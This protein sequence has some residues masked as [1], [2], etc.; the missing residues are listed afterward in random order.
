MGIKGWVWRMVALASLALMAGGPAYA[1]KAVS[2]ICVA[3]VGTGETAEAVLA[4]PGRF[5][6]DKDQTKL[7]SGHFVTRIETVNASYDPAEHY[8]L[9]LASVWQESTRVIFRYD[10]NSVSQLTF[11]S[12]TLPQY[13]TIG[14]IIEIPAPVRKAALNSVA[15][16]TFGS[17]NL[18][19]VV[20]AAEV[21]PATEAERI[22]IALAAIYAAFAG[23]AL[24][25]VAYNVSLWFALKNRFQL[26]YCNMVIA[27]A[28]YTFV[29][30]GAMSLLLPAI[31]N[32]D[33][34]RINYV[35]LAAAAVTGIR[36]IRHFFDEDICGPWL[37]IAIK[38]SG[39]SAIITAIAFAALAPALIWQLDKAYFVAMALLLITAIP[40]FINAVRM[41]ARYARLFLLAWMAP[42]VTSAF[43]AA[44]GFGLVPYSLLIDNGSI[45]AMAVEALLSSM[46]VTARVRHLAIERDHAV[47][48]E[49]TAILLAATDP[50]TGLLNRRSFLDRAIGVRAQQRLMLI[51]IDHFKA[52]NDRLG[53]DAG[54]QVLAAVAQVIEAWRPAKSLA[55]RLGGEEFGLLLPRRLADVYNP[56][57]LLDAVRSAVMPQGAQVTIS[58]G[59]S[60]G[61]LSSEE[62]WKRLY[63]LADSALYRAKADGRDRA[64]KA[65]DFRNAA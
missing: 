15:I 53:H 44:Y 7:G 60:Q 24:A 64:C 54:D 13:L 63:R 43:R 1:S 42:L 8:V 30:S 25:L 32:N 48:G 26:D 29:S 49:Q 55:V 36:F 23:L 19:G 50:L 34:L 51:D 45:I 14:A 27:L 59:L 2:A 56:E 35:V 52:V 20:I 41:R 39:W 65:T 5:S 11:D 57:E 62:D 16:E 17:A 6:C 61:K 47:A 10:D 37:R 58:V 3:K 28:A 40:L 31:A 33:R 46:M 12:Q 38:V 4:Q 18:R 21:V 22:K 9:R